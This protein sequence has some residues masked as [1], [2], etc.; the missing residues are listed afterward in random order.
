MKAV[1]FVA[2]LLSLAVWCQTPIKPDAVVATIDGKP[3]TAAEA[4]A[5]LEANAPAARQNLLK[6]PKAFLE[7][8]TLFRKFEA[9]AEKAQLDRQSPTKEQLDLLKMQYG[10][11]RMQILANAQ[12]AAATDAIPVLESEKKKFY[13]ANPDRY[14]QAKV[15]VLLVQFRANPAPQAKFLSE[16]EAK[17]KVDRLASQIR[18]GADFVKLVRENSD[19]A[20]SKAKDGDY[21]PIRRSD[22][23]PDNIKSAIFSLKP[24]QVSDPVRTPAG[25]YLFRLE[26]LSPEPYEKV[27]NDIF[28]EIRQTRF[29]ELIETQR[30]SISVKIENQDFF[31]Q[32][33]SAPAR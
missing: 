21:P 24:G 28:V 11:A 5:I 12:I 25:F 3:L 26:D 31:T 10:L 1:I 20:D 27:G 18:A 17:V 4:T 22:Q 15:K 19:D 2:P 32:A 8:L 30:K 13:E 14:L 29:G 33:A 9:I 23:A 7:Q 16:A 6:D